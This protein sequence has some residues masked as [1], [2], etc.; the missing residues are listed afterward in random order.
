MGMGEPFLNYKNVIKAIRIL[1]DK[2]KFNIGARKI[3]ISTCGIPDK[4][5]KLAEE[6]LP[7][8]LAVS[9]NAPDDE[10]RSSLMSI[11]KTYPIKEVLN[12]VK[13]YTEKTRRRAM[14]EYLMINNLNDLPSQAKKLSKL[15]KGML[16]F[17]N[18]I[19]YNKDPESRIYDLEP[20]RKERISEFKN[21]LEASGIRV[22]ERFRLGR[23]VRAACGQLVYKQ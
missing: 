7:V 23:D 5:R 9:L 12:S 1:N 11:N 22:T 15:I 4:I 6:K 21:I 3:S 20:S 16:C 18:L 13:F 19:P 2:N 17:V 10:I 8:N 14:F